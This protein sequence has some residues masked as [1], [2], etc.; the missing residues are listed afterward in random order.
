MDGEQF[1]KLRVAAGFTQ[2]HMAEFLGLNPFTISRWENG[3]YD[4][5]EMAAKIVSKLRPRGK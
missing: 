3:H 2:K 1:K 4:V 5:P